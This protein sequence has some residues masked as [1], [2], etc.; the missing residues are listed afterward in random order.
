MNA[1]SK[2]K[3]DLGQVIT[4]GF[5]GTS[6]SDDGVKNA[7]AQAEAGIIGGVILFRYNIENPK[8]L[9]ELLSAFKNA[10]TN[11]P[12]FIALDQE[13][14]KV[15]R[16]NAQKGFK[17]F[18]SAQ[19][20]ARE[21]TPEQAF[22]Q[23]REMGKM[24]Q[25]FGFNFN[26]APCV[27]VDTDPPGAAIGKLERSY[28]LNPLVV[29]QYAFS[30]IKALKEF[31]VISCLKHFPGHGSARDDSHM[32]LVD[33]TNNWQESELVPY[34]ELNQQHMI[35]SVMSA[36]LVHNQ[37]DKNTP[38]LFSKVW[39]DKLRNEIGFNGVLVTDDLHMGAIIHNFTISEIVTGALSSGHDLLIFSNN[40]LAAQAQGIRKDQH[41]NS[42]TNKS[43]V[44]VPDPQVAETV[45]TEIEK[46]L[47]AGTLSEIR[48][49]EAIAHVIA[50]KNKYR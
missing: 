30:M 36:H 44:T 45:I 42:T 33:I 8:Q 19:K 15:Q 20:V 38:I 43:T 40:T 37:V 25:E 10:K 46:S 9:K 16:I 49:E 13:G 28:S 5:L 7:I 12:L 27:D 47:N 41:D 1:L 29:S 11:Y 48:V 6:V 24:L 31:H 17:D 35:D 26:F 50:L 14:G 18:Y 39:I 4:T 34:K 21:L 22:T 2:F 32:G 23:Y 3:E